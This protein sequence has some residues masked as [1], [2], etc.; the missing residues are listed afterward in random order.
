MLSLLHIENIAV[1]SQADITFDQGFNVLTGETGAGKSIV[2]DSIGAIMG[3]RTSRD[4]IRTGAKT[5]RVSALFRDLPP[6]PWFEEQGAGPDENGELLIERSIQADGK[7]VC[8][9][10]GRPLLVTQLRELGQQLVNVHGQH[11]GQQLLDEERHLGYLDSFGRTQDGLSAFTA[12][13]AQVRDLRREKEKLQMDD[14]EKARRLDT[15][16]Y[17]IE[18]LEKAQLQEGE[19]EEL[20]QRREVLRN[21]ERLTDAVDGAWQALTGGE[22]GEGAVSLLMEAGNRLAQGGRYSEGLREL[23]EKAEQLRCDAD[24]LAELVRDLRGTLDFY[25]GELD[26]IEERLDRLYRL[27]K[28]YGGTVAEMLAYLDRC[29]EELDAIQFSEDRINRLDKELE[30]A[31]ARAVK[32]GGELSARRHKA[33]QELAKRIQSELTQLD[34]PKVRFQVE[35]APKDAPDGMDAT[36]MDTVRF[37]MSANVGEALKPINKIA[38]GGELSR[39]MLALKNVLAE[40]EQVSTLIFDEVDTGVSG[41]AAVKVA[42]KLFEVSKGRQVLC[43][44][45]LPQ[46]A[47]MGDVHFSVEKGEADGRTFTR[48]E[49]LDRPRRREELARLSGG[50]ATAVMLEGAEELLATAQDY[51]TGAKKKR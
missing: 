18:E 19:D 21:A 49:R 39:I 4:L 1:I 45:H 11:D 33:A 37:L 12:A 13:Y 30:K 9:V 29:R 26:E 42:R 44:T 28:K 6:L 27:K 31:L 46:I 17:Q 15:L 7:N 40:T 25:P 16:T 48:V 5:A 38:S 36:G 50:Q 22:D 51:K 3:E 14:G 23:S 35:F 8:R 10:N 47:A 2:I 41:R 43:V 20:S 34:M 24:D 32:A